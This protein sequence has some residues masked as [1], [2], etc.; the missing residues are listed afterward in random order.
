[1]LMSSDVKPK[2]PSS[3]STESSESAALE[4]A[5]ERLE[6]ILTGPSDED[7]NSEVNAAEGKMKYVAAATP[8]PPKAPAGSG[9][10]KS[11]DDSIQ[12]KQ[13]QVQS[14]SA[15]DDAGGKTTSPRPKAP[16]PPPGFQVVKSTDVIPPGVERRTH[17]PINSNLMDKLSAMHDN[18]PSFYQAVA[19]SMQLTNVYGQE[20]T[21]QLILTEK[22]AS[23]VYSDVS[24]INPYDVLRVNIDSVINNELKS[25]LQKDAVCTVQVNT[26]KHYAAKSPSYVSRR[27]VGT[28]RK[29][30][31]RAQAAK[32]S[33]KGP[34]GKSQAQAASGQS[35]KPLRKSTRRRAQTKNIGED[36]KMPKHDTNEELMQTAMIPQRTS[37]GGQLPND[38]NMDTTD[39]K[40]HCNDTSNTQSEDKSA[41]TIIPDD[42][43]AETCPS[44]P[45]VESKTESVSTV[46]DE[47]EHQMEAADGAI[48]TEHASTQEQ[49]EPEK[50]VSTPKPVVSQAA[51]TGNG[52]LQQRRSLT[53][54]LTVNT[55]LANDV[56]RQIDAQLQAAQNQMAQS[57]Y[58]QGHSNKIQMAPAQYNQQQ[59][60]YN[61]GVTASSTHPTIRELLNLPPANMMHQNQMLMNNGHGYNASNGQY[62]QQQSGTYPYMANT[63]NFNNFNSFQGYQNNPY[64]GHAYPTQPQQY[65]VPEQFDMYG[66]PINNWSYVQNSGQYGNWQPQMQGQVSGWGYAPAYGAFSLGQHNNF[67]NTCPQPNFQQQQ[68]TSQQPNVSTASS[69]DSS[70]SQFDD[71]NL[72]FKYPSV[73]NHSQPNY[74]RPVPAQTTNTMSAVESQPANNSTVPEQPVVPESSAAD[75]S[76]MN[77]DGLDDKV[78]DDIE[79]LSPSIAKMLCAVPSSE[80]E[81]VTKFFDDKS[82][83][84][85]NAADSPKLPDIPSPQTEAMAAEKS[86][87]KEDSAEQSSGTAGP[88]KNKLDGLTT[89]GATAMLMEYWERE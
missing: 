5:N 81:K 4:M 88:T 33:S 26:H 59:Y 75:E 17:A 57:T 86:A 43:A 22:P 67:Q 37:T 56:S 71:P 40:K 21:T 10:K 45:T 62:F 27:A 8:K 82:S 25:Q 39:V 44:I 53:S 32:E 3:M 61:S 12:K 30:L 76:I 78:E 51:P 69:S 31:K 11:D 34:A 70:Q 85:P 52:T 66:N 80:P 50:S 49:V 35:T 73:P 15:N 28:A 74:T 47:S 19:A 64:S 38:G 46:A 58:V 36:P 41:K 77:L 18:N 79:K 42:T 87:S 24:K 60:G 1:M 23:A 6:K 20:V 48:G 68:N 65:H 54:P 29:R 16:G 84:S 63:S 89:E 14:Q 55:D 2:S 9:K 72:V 83:H 7:S 13:E